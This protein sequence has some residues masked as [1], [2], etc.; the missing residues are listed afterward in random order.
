MIV[1]DRMLIS[2]SFIIRLNKSDWCLIT[3]KSLKAGV[4]ALII[5]NIIGWKSTMNIS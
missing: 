4:K 3:K 2:L 5:K 1:G